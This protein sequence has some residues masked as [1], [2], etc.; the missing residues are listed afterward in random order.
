V[1]R[2]PKRTPWFHDFRKRLRFEAAAKAEFGE[3]IKP[4]KIGK[5]WGSEIRYVLKVDV[6]EY[7]EERRLTISLRNFAEPSL[8]EVEVDG[9]T[10]SPHRR[11][12]RGLCLWRWDASSE[13]QWTADEGLLALIQYCRIHLFQE[14]YWRETGGYEG[15]VWAGE[16]APHG[17]AKDEAA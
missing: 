5:G 1:A 14:E 8:G 17:D 16:E 2:R 10:D 3:A 4:Q 11:G 9:S 15:G 12:E 6:P 13:R 7:D